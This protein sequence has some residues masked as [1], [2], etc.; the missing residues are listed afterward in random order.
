[1]GLNKPHRLLE[2]MP[3]L[4]DF[5]RACWGAQVVKEVDTQFKFGEQPYLGFERLTMCPLQR[6]MFALEVGCIP[7]YAPHS[8]TGPQL[9]SVPR[10]MARWM[11]Y[12]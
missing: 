7:C 6:K 12:T 5:N 4:L 9:G 10:R 3:G 2:T 11:A 1:M 8:C